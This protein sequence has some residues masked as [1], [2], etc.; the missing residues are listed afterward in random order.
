M[1]DSMKNNN[2]KRV[3]N[4]L[5]IADCYTTQLFGHAQSEQRFDGCQGVFKNFKCVGL[6]GGPASQ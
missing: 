3:A 4:N 2:P 5:A 6:H 1:R